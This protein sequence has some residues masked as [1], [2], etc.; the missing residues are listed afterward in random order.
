MNMILFVNLMLR[1]YSPRKCE[2]VIVNFVANFN[3]WKGIT[4]QETQ[5]KSELF[6]AEV[7]REAQNIQLVLL[8]KLYEFYS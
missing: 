2:Y 8:L 4:T 6:S 7:P 3:R 5:K 1:L